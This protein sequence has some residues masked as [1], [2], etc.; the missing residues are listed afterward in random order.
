[1]TKRVMIKGLRECAEIIRRHIGHD[2]I[3]DPVDKRVIEDLEA[4]AADLEQQLWITR[5][6]AFLRKHF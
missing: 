6:K 3:L 4:T 1:M 5:F 2:P